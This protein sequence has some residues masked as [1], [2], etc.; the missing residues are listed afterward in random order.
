M[1]CVLSVGNRNILSQFESMRLF[2]L[3]GTKQKK[4]KLLK[5]QSVDCTQR[6]EINKAVLS[7]G[8]RLLCL[9]WAKGRKKESGKHQNGYN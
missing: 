6:L 7:P 1:R 4:K 3:H 9:S 5:S 8:E 2:I